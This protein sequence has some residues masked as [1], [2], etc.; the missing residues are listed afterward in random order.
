M[1]AG[2][3][4]TKIMLKF[5]ELKE[6]GYTNEEII[7]LLDLKEKEIILNVKKLLVNQ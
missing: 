1:D 5:L 4:I 6:L 7:D 3:C 2:I